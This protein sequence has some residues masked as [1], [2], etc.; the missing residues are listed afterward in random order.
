MPASVS[1]RHCL[2]LIPALGL[3]DARLA[4]AGRITQINRL[5]AQIGDTHA[6]VRG[7][8][9]Q[10]VAQVHRAGQCGRDAEDRGHID[11]HPGADLVG[12]GVEAQARI[13]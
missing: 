5:Y 3:A 6:V 1:R 13:P 12:V 11:L 2:Q 4:A 10:A 9:A 7:L 8:E